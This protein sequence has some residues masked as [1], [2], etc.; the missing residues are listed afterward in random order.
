[1]AVQEPGDGN[2]NRDGRLVYN[3]GNR[4]Y[5]KQKKLDITGRT[6]P[7]CLSVVAKE[8]KALRPFD[9]LLITCDDFPTATT[10][11]P[12]IARDENLAI[13]VQKKTGECWEIRLT[14]E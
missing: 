7:Y 11:V 9:E 10:I 14:R 1:V 12:R 13:D 4:E 8:A 5:M 3:G 2:I 6:G